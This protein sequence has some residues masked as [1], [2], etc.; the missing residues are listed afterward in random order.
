MTIIK[1]NR[2]KILIDNGC[3]DLSNMGDAA[4]LQV[5]VKRLRN[6]WPEASIGVVTN[7]VRYLKQLCQQATAI[8]A[9]GRHSWFC[10]G[11]ILGRVN[12]LLPH[13]IENNLKNFGRW[14]RYNFPL[15]YTNLIKL[16]TR[17][18]GKDIKN[19]IDFLQIFFGSDLLVI[20]GGGT[21][22]D[23]F[24]YSAMTILDTLD[25]AHKHG[26]TTAMFSQGIGPIENPKLYKR[27]KAVLPAVKLITIR[28]SLASFSILKS[29]GV[30]Q[31]N[32]IVTGDDAVEAA[33]EARPSSV[34]NLIGANLRIS[35]Y[36]HVNREQINQIGK[37][38]QKSA[39]KHK[40]RIMPLPVSFYNNESDSEIIT[41][42]I[43]AKY[44][45]KEN[46]K[47]DNCTP[48]TIIEKVSSCRVVVTGS[49]HPAVFALS[50]GIPVIAL[51]KS[52]YYKNKFLGLAHQFGYGCETIFLDDND[53]S[54]KVSYWIDYFWDAA[55]QL[56]PFLIKA[57][58]RQIASSRDAYRFFFDAAETEL[59]KY[60]PFFDNQKPQYV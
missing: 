56:R 30:N 44:L 25:I 60:T 8:C 58:E 43:P 49:Y 6:L 13:P 20:S 55:N 22:N 19:I 36:S 16:K 2:R 35:F 14:S 26:I 23:H 11:N 57:A 41:Q 21:I 1:N 31:N 15:L 51:A 28:E 18:R 50:Q 47:Q 42:M 12:K 10:D 33:Y 9:D 59:K 29:L 27:A 52:Q 17:I 48:Q 46:M 45:V 7:K 32:I 5:A 53:F 34:G 54:S 39:N 3:Y 37:I 38:F 4:M 40:S 24:K